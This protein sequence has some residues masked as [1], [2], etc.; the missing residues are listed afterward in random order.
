MPLTRSNLHD[1]MDDLNVQSIRFP[2]MNGNAVV[3]V[4]VTH[5]A[6]AE[7]AAWD[8]LPHNLTKLELFLRYRDKIEHIASSEFDRGQIDTSSDATIV[9]VPN[10]KL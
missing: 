4:Q 7:R 10:G 5:R 3:T 8:R 1:P 9:R 2:M 6:L